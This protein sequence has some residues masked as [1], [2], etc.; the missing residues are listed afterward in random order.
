MK[1][2]FHINPGAQAFISRV[3]VFHIFASLP[4]S[5]SFFQ[6]S[7]FTCYCYFKVHA[8]WKGE[9]ILSAVVEIVC[10]PHTLCE[11]LLTHTHTTYT[12]LVAKNNFW[13]VGCIRDRKCK[14]TVCTT[15]ILT[16][17]WL[18]PR[19][20]LS[21]PIDWGE[22]RERAGRKGKLWNPAKASL[23]SKVGGGFFCFFFMWS[24]LHCLL[25]SA[26]EE[27]QRRK[28]EFSQSYWSRRVVAR[29][30][31]VNH[32]I[33]SSVFLCKNCSQCKILFLEN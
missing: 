4:I 32:I 18:Q 19:V 11:G 3:Y 31:Q 29:L 15:V 30:L 26:A 8:E 21:S 27:T 20:S 7:E 16:S 24:F 22:T 17:L 33:R 5:L 2:F 23:L 25:D 12:H 9:E 14:G 28:Y 13:L 1:W 6:G 10:M